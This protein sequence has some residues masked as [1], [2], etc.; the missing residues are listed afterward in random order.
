VDKPETVER[1]G[2]E[3]K[4][5]KEVRRGDK[6]KAQEVRESRRGVTNKEDVGCQERA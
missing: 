6:L 2:Y 1:M 3:L 5:Q 4:G